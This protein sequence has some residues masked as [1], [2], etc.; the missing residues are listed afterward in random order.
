MNSENIKVEG[1][2]KSITPD[3]AS[4]IKFNKAN[5]HSSQAVENCLVVSYPYYPVSP[6]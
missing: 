4:K 2:K 5:K 6:G 3:S 1:L